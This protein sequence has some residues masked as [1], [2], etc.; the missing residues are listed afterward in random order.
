MAVMYSKLGRCLG[1]TAKLGTLARTDLCAWVK[2]LWDKLMT[3]VGLGSSKEDPWGNLLG[4]GVPSQ[5]LT[6]LA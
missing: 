1:D 3:H 4:G 5:E 2:G 6:L